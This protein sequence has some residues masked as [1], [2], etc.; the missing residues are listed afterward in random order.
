MLFSSDSSNLD[1]NA[2]V[3]TISFVHVIDTGDKVVKCATVSLDD[4]IKFLIFK[5]APFLEMGTLLF[6]KK[7]LSFLKKLSFLQK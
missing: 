6:K 7:F 4:K 1:P 2:D 5:P 3:P